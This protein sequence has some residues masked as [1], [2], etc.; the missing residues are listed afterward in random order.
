[1]LVSC[2][3]NNPLPVVIKSRS[4]TLEPLDC[5]VAK[6]KAH[7]LD[8]IRFAINRQGIAGSLNHIDVSGIRDMS[9]LFESSLFNGDISQ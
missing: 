2:N 1:M 3:L 4:R 6:D 8:L 7:L 9:N 5:V